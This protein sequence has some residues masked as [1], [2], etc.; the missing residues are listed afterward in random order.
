MDLIKTETVAHVETTASTTVRRSL[1]VWFEDE[2]VGTLVTDQGVWEF[3]YHPDWIA[4]P[5][6]FVLS[7]HFQLRSDSFVD[8][9][10]DRRVRWFFDNLLPE[11]G[12]RQALA[13]LAK[14]DEN[15]A[16]GLL[17]RYGD[18]SAGALTFLP[19]DGRAPALGGYRE[20]S[21]EELKALL[22]KLPE[23][24]L[25]AAKGRARMSLAGAQHKLGLHRE[26]ERWLLPASGSSSVI[27]KPDNTRK[28]FPHC[29]A[30]EHF[31]C[32]LAQTVGVVVPRSELVHLPEPIYVI[33]RHDRLVEE[34]RVH[35]RHQIDLCQVLNRWPRFKYE[36]D[37]GVSVE[38]AY[39][40]LQATRQPAR[41]RSQF[42]RWFV[43]NYLIG[44]SGAHAKNISFLVSPGRIDLAPAYDLLCVRA[45]GSDYDYMAMSIASET[46]YG[47]IE[48]AQWDALAA[49]LNVPAALL[50]RVRRE[51]A[52]IVPQEA[53]TLLTR[54]AS[55]ASFRKNEREFL[56]EVVAVIETHASYMKETLW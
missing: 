43:F 34:G 11:G 21:T 52:T 36:S 46:R 47:W 44:N 53:K 17:T 3:R 8:T 4:S 7:P 24:P 12:V 38:A 30:N 2:R 16:F 50:T 31:C 14:V 15:D 20:L 28:E 41:S 22:R 49:T 6:A 19:D 27:I 37:G 56:T 48:K 10:D 25:I 18:E 35:R 9:A 51:L 55:V 5:K 23:V 32:R 33:E 13:R 39:G 40:A 54:Q 1:A 42:L 45:Y 26:N 29:P